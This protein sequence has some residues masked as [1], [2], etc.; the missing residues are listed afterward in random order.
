MLPVMASA[1]PEMLIVLVPEI[2]AT[3][4]FHVVVRPACQGERRP[5]RTGQRPRWQFSTFLFCIPSSLALILL[6][7]F[8]RLR[9]VVGNLH[10]AFAAVGDLRSAGEKGV[11]D[12]RPVHGLAQLNLGPVG[13]NWQGRT[14]T[15]PLAACTASRLA[16]GVPL[17]ERAIA[18]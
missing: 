10:A 1:R 3:P 2:E 5:R 17:N 8:C 15:V 18:E 12:H 9:R 6:L 13:G 16:P 14:N 7:A 11:S 4:P